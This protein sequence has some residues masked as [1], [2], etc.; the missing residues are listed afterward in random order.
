MLAFRMGGT[1]E[2]P[3]GVRY[4]LRPAALDMRY[5]E[6]ARAPQMMSVGLQTR[7]LVIPRVPPA[8]SGG[9]ITSAS[10]RACG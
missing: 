1:M 7:L 9:T 10:C 2:A 5:R 6:G 3:L 4:R 8:W